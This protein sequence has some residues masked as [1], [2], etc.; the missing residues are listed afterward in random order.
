VNA[1]EDI[2]GNDPWWAR[3]PPISL[4]KRLETKAALRKVLRARRREH[5]AGLD[6][7]M[8]A[9]MLM[10]PPGPV[11]QMVPDDAVIGLYMA[12]PQEAPAGG[13]ARF[14][15]EAGHTIAMPSFA[16]RESPMVFRRWDSAH[17]EELLET[18][19]YGMLQPMADAPVMVP[20]V[21][22]VPLIGFTADGAR[23]GQGGGHYDRW[24][25]EHPGTLTIGLAWD[26]QLE[27]TLP[28]EAHDQPL[29]AVVT[30]TRLYGPW[31]NP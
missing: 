22:F 31:E 6:Q 27:D 21:L 14:F 28:H 8:R 17:V 29:R 18:G 7:R 23:L 13:Y 16:T 24:L 3:H 11:V 1:S 15:Q 26:C 5:V 10:R 2:Y 9:L 30:P 25:P 4:E 12:G 19:P 20:D